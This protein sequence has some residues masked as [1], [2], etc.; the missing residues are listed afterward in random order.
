MRT[1]LYVEEKTDC[2]CN[3]QKTDKPVADGRLCKGMHRADYAA[4]C[5]ECTEDGKQKRGENQP[6]VPGLQHPAFFLHH[7]GMEES[8]AGEPRHQRRVLH[9]IPAPVASPTQDGV[10]PMRAQKNTAG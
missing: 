1:I 7:Y 9:R 10:G 3:R 6:H 5:E 8:G 4:P 2:K